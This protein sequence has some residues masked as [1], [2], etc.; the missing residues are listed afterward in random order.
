VTAGRART[1]AA[2]AADCPSIKT[3]TRKVTR[4]GGSVV[5][6][7]DVVRVL[8]R[9]ET[10]CQVME[11]FRASGGNRDRWAASDRLAMASAL[12]QT[13]DWL[14]L[15]HPGSVERAALSRIRR[16]LEGEAS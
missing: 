7:A 12:T 14:E 10:R 2:K 5:K 13:E 3:G 8:G 16:A 11:R 4:T 15:E 9:D 6:Y 1:R